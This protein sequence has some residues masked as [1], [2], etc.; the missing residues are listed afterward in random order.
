MSRSPAALTMLLSMFMVI[1]AAL[2]VMSMYFTW[3][4]P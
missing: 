2:S 4:F 3:A 1:L